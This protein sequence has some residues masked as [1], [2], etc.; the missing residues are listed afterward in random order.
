[1]QKLT[2]TLAKTLPFGS[3]D[4]YFRDAETPGL[5]LKISKSDK[6]TWVY[7]GRVHGRSYRRSLGD[8]RSL[9]CKQ[10]REMA[11]EVYVEL[12]NGHDRFA[13]A[14]E[15]VRQQK[16]DRAATMRKEPNL[17]EHVAAYVKQPHLRPDTVRFYNQLATV[18]L[19]DWLHL[20]PLKFTSTDVERLYW[21]IAEKRSGIRATK[22]LKFVQSICKRAEHKLPI[23]ANLRMEQ[24]RPRRARLEPSH[25]KILWQQLNQ[26]ENTP[27]VAAAKMALLTGLRVAELKRLNV[28]DIDFLEGTATLRETKNHTDHKVYLSALLIETLRPFTKDHQPES[29]LFSCFDYGRA[30][31][32][33]VQGLPAFSAHDLRK[34]FAIT[35]TECG[36]QY[37]VIKSALNHTGGDVT[38]IHY[39]HATPSQLRACFQTVSE[40]FS[41]PSLKE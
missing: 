16:L 7:E 40:Y 17:R 20:D 21:S 31:L 5:A 19:A 28:G 35:A 9:P 30:P 14:K 32:R 41:E 24:P 25:G 36:V 3:A 22:A 18:E 10:A 38:L 6:R 39:L 37:P 12:R 4:K 34:L 23:P 27:S 1:M 8:A 2:D 13:A 33:R 15:V 29:E 26:M 11:R